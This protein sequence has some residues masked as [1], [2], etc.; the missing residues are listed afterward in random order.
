MREIVILSGA[1]FDLPGIYC[2]MESPGTDLADRFD[3]AVHACRAAGDGAC[4]PG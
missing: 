1:E 2:W 4:F 3:A